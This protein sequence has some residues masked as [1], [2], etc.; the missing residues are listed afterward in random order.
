M[1]AEKPLR[2][3]MSRVRRP[4]GP[5]G[6]DAQTRQLDPETWLV[7]DGPQR[8]YK[9]LGGDD[10]RSGMLM[11]RAR[12][13]QGYWNA[14]RQLSRFL[15]DEHVNFLFR[16]L[17]VNCV[18]DVGANTGQYARGIR[19][20]G[21]R[22]RIVSFEPVAEPLAKLQENAANDPEWRVVPVAL[23]DEDTTTEILATPGKTLSSLLPATDFGKDFNAKLAAPE[24]Q[25]VEV[26][27]LDGLFD[28]AIEGI[29]DPCVFLKMD[30]QGFDL[31]AFRGGGARIDEIVG[32][33][34]EVACVPIY[35]GMPRLPE[36]LTE[37]ESRG[38]E[39]SGMFMVSRHRPTLRV[40]EYDMTMVR[41]EA[42][43]PRPTGPARGGTA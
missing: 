11:D 24:R 22:G 18:L 3:A 35:E 43:P 7:E 4:R 17:G 14:E 34:S 9:P 5:G 21:Y 25:Q 1:F 10:A 36:Q 20:R 41:P 13:R 38:F 23:G 26:R 6:P 16:E 40:I 31:P 15:A 28:E 33:Q 37:Y 19:N 2:A 42:V 39:I 12:L 30:T 32:M 29:A 27:R 8:Q